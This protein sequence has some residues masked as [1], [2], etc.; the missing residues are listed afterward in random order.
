MAL[1]LLIPDCVG[2]ENLSILLRITFNEIQ[3]I[4][5]NFVIY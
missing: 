5:L 2:L 4:D 1:L 3:M